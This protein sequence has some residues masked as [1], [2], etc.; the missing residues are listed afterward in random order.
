MAMTQPM[1]RPTRLPEALYDYHVV[2]LARQEPHAGTR[3]RSLGMAHWQQHGSLTCTAN[4]YD[5]LWVYMTKG[6]NWL[7]RLRREGLAG[8]QA[9]PRPGCANKFTDKQ[10]A[11]LPEGIDELTAEP[12]AGGVKGQD[13][14]ARLAAQFGVH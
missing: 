2:P 12:P 1:A 5:A 8:L 13:S 9:T 10:L 6:Q 7:N 4:V 14:Q 11:R 3:Q